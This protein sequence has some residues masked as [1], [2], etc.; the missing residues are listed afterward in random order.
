MSVV[1][2][3]RSVDWRVIDFGPLEALGAFV[4]AQIAVAAVLERPVRGK[5]APVKP[6]LT[7]RRIGWPLAGAVALLSLAVTW[8]R[9]GDEPRS[10]ALVAEHTHGARVLLA[11]AR[12]LTDRDHDGFS[13]RFGGGDCDD[14]DARVHPG[15]EEIR[16]NGID[17]DCDG[18]DLAAKPSAS[19]HPTTTAGTSDAAARFHFDGNVVVIFVDTLRA[20]RFD[21]KHMPRTFARAKSAVVFSNVYA[22][23]PN[24][25]R[26]VPSF[27]TS[28]FPAEVRWLPGLTNFPPL[29]PAP[30]NTTFFRALKDAGFHTIGIF[31]HFYMKP[32]GVL[33][34]GFDSWTN[35]GALTLHDSN[36]DIAAPRITERVVT[37]IRDLGRDKTRFV[38]FTH[39]FDPHSRYMTS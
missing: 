7:L 16:G 36:T 13:P 22:Q 23:A 38:L 6:G 17:E 21:A 4:G 31:S 39:L 3:L 10:L 14:H 26:S 35:D 11:V 33:T 8:L 18:R 34:D 29:R 37:A 19:P 9:F 27:M 30:E 32:G 25:P 12:R 28:R 5:A 2:A 1:P 20:D 15:A 24:T